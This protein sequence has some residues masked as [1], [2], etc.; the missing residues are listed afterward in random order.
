[1]GTAEYQKR[2]GSVFRDPDRQI[3]C[4]HQKGVLIK[5][6]KGIYKYDPDFIE[7]KKLEDFTTE[8]KIEILEGDGYRCVVCGR[9]LQDGIELQVDRIKPKRIG[10]ANQ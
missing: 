7:I 4:L 2:T 10:V 9:G 6:S 1:M 8:Q 3:R 5:V